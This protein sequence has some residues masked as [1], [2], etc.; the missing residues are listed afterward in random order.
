[1]SLTVD[2]SG[3]VTGEMKV[4]SGGGAGSCDWSSARITGRAEGSKL[5][6]A[7]KGDRIGG[8]SIG[9]ATLILGGA[10]QTAATGPSALPSPDG[11][12]RGTYKCD[13]SPNAGSLG[14]QFTIELQ[15]QLTNAIGT[16]RTTSARSQDN[17]IEIRISVDQ[18]TVS[19][20]R[21]FAGQNYAGGSGISSR[22][23]LTGRY[24]GNTISAIGKEKNPDRQCTLALNRA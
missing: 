13:E 15:V 5:L 19:V 3:N 2:A 10:S 6:L 4:L 18:S 24:D 23:I 12:W 11:L 9:E 22:G 7:I 16:W 17:T 21:F 14:T 8:A 20:T 1:M